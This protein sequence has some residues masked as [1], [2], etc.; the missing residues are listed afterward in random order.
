[1]CQDYKHSD[2][3]YSNANNKKAHHKEK[4]TKKYLTYKI[5]T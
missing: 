1:M 2:N 4:S 3:M 5:Y